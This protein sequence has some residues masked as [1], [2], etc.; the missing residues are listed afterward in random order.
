DDRPHVAG[1]EVVG[2]EGLV[3]RGAELVDGVRQLE[4]VHLA[5]AP[6]TLQVLTQP[7]HRWT[8]V[9]PVGP[10]ALEYA[11]SVVQRVRQDVDLRLVPVDELAV[12][13]DL[14]GLLHGTPFGLGER[15][16]PILPGRPGPR[17]IRM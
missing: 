5:R 12:H 2:R 14:L 13:P 1:L 11:G 15:D 17:A 8:A 7:E 16:A 10:D 3:H 4:E 6:E 9:R